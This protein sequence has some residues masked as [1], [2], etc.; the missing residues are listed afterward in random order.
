VTA[1]DT[2]PVKVNASL[3]PPTVKKVAPKVVSHRKPKATG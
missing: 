1:Q 3:T 2:A